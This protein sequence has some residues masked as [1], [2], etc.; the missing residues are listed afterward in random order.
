VA[1]EGPVPPGATAFD[2]LL[3]TAMEDHPGE[4]TLDHV[5]RH[6]LLST[7]EERHARQPTQT[8]EAR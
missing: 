6:A 2:A 8:S 1:R 7:L 3:A 4:T 5:V